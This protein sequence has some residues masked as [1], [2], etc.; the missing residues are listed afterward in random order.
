MRTTKLV[1]IIPRNL[2]RFQFSP[3]VGQR[4]REERKRLKLTQ[5]Q[6]ATKLGISRRTIINHETEIFPV[7]LDILIKLDGLGA[8]CF[9][10]LFG[11][12]SWSFLPTTKKQSG[13]NERG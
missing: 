9:Y 4:Y 7:S 3:G 13:D 10:I 5:V 8:D 2:P 6:L 11:H 12:H 1:K